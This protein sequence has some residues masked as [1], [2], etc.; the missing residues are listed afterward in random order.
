ML[1]IVL[2][3]A[4]IGVVV[5]ESPFVGRAPRV[6]DEHILQG[7]ER[8]ISV[9]QDAG[10]RFGEQD[11]TVGELLATAHGKLAALGDVPCQQLH[12]LLGVGGRWCHVVA[13]H[14]CRGQRHGIVVDGVA[15]LFVPGL[16]SHP[17]AGFLVFH[18]APW[19]QVAEG[20]HAALSHVVACQVHH[21]QVHEPADGGVGL[22]V[23]LAL[24]AADAQLAGHRTVEP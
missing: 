7:V 13:P 8:G 10:H 5:G 11:D 3:A 2:A 12:H 4:G 23:D 9:G 17:F 21:G 15:L 22:A 1:A 18:E 19:L 16:P 14:Q 6:G 20:A 24:T